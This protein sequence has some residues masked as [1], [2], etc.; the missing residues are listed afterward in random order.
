MQ[1][2]IFKDDV[3]QRI[4]GV[5]LIVGSVV[6][7]IFNILAPRVDDPNDMAKVTQSISDNM[8][9][10]W[11]ADKLLL[12]ASMWVL[13]V[14][15]VGVYRSI[16]TGGAAA[17]ARVGLYGVLVG[18][19]LWSVAFALE[20]LGLPPT[21]ELWE[22]ATGAEKTTLFHIASALIHVRLGLLSIIIIVYWLALA[23]LGIGMTLSG[24]YPRLL[25]WPPIV[26]GVGLVIVGLI[27]AFAEYSQ[28][29]N[30]SFGVLALLN[31]V[32]ALALGIWITRKAW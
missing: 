13:M 32:W 23:F 14:G 31:T 3:F 8:G 11:E 18:T 2:E 12:A 30:L 27:T 19:A 24:V 9:G 20:G 22:T 16:P 26:L 15:S 5:C 29:L 4:A 17:W 1:Q 25:G 10:F 28:V 21:V 6:G 7:A